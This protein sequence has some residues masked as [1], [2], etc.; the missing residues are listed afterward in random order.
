MDAVPGEQLPAR[1]RLADVDVVTARV[2]LQEDQVAGR[3]IGLTMR[4]E[5]GS[6]V[7]LAETIEG[8][9]DVESAG[10]ALPPAVA[11]LLQRQEALA[12]ADGRLLKA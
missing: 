7:G 9:D 8:C 1:I 2:E 10:V 6:F 3:R 12:E 4:G 5:R 11:G